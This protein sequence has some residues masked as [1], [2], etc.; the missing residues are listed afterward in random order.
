MFLQTVTYQRI[1][2]AL[3]LAARITLAHFSIL[4]RS[5]LTLGETRVSGTMEYIYRDGFG[6]SALMLPARITLPHFSVS[7]AMSL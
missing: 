3:I 7:S 2:C 4:S 5:N 6:Y 1:Y